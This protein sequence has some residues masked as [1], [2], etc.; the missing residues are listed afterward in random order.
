MARFVIA[1][2]TYP[3]SIPLE[4]QALAPDVVVPV[5]SLILAGEQQFAMFNDLRRKYHWVLPTYA[6]GSLEG[7]LAS[8][9]EH[10]IAPA[11]AKITELRAGK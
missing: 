3:S 7:L 1:D 9:Q 6:Y 2:L 11:E 8:M 10:V 4:L 5:Q